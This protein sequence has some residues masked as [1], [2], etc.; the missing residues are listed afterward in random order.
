[1]ERFTI[2]EFAEHCGGIS[3]NGADKKIDG[4]IKKVKQGKL[5]GEIERNE[6]LI[7]GK[8]TKVVYLSS[9]LIHLVKKNKNELNLNEVNQIE[10]ESIELNVTKSKQTDEL[11]SIQ[12]NNLSFSFIEN[13]ISELITTQKQMISYAE[14]AGQVKLLTSSEDNYRNE[15]L[16]LVQE[17]AVLNEKF[18]QLEL[19]SKQITEFKIRIAELEEENKSLKEKKSSFLGFFKK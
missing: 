19:N 8:I 3:Y 17:N 6:E 5:N 4:L 18:K 16:K 10:P 2:Q 15:Y 11:N 1:M 9:N 13:V 12:S 7:D 14:Q